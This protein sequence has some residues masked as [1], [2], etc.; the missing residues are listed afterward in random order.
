MISVLLLSIIAQH[1][2]ASDPQT[3]VPQPLAAKQEFALPARE[4]LRYDGEFYFGTMRRLSTDGENAEGYFSWCGTRITYQATF[5]D[6]E[7]DQ[8]YE[9]D[10][11]SGARRMVSTIRCC[12]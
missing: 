9:L 3:T 2:S 10:L 1:P 7:C 12:R 6:R 4:D 5:G 11:L 8:I